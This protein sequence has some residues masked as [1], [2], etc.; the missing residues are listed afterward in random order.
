[1]PTLSTV[2]LKKVLQLAQR[3]RQEEQLEKEEALDE[4]FRRL[5]LEKR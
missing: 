5:G 2:D 1:M 3:L 4:A